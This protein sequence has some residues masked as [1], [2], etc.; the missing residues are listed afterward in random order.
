MKFMLFSLPLFYVLLTSCNSGAKNENIETSE[1]VEI[2]AL[3]GAASFT[4]DQGVV[5][6]SAHDLIKQHHGTLN[7]NKAEIFTDGSD[8]VGGMFEI[9]MSSVTVNDLTEDKGKSKLEKHLKSSD[10]L[11]IDAHPTGQFEI[12]S[13]QK[14]EGKEGATHEITGNLTLKNITK[15]ITFPAEIQIDA[16][17][18][19]ARTP[20][21][22]ITR[23]DWN[24]MYGSNLIGTAKD[25]LISNS[26][27]L[28]LGVTAIKN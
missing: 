20:D 15:S 18:F 23:T 24:I 17:S 6:W 7:I 21:F 19:R 5:F 10:F 22:T 8:L 11:E 4:L 26:V 12:S 16:T 3:E 28:S 2:Q 1:A 25:K 9:D 13:V 27:T 14:I